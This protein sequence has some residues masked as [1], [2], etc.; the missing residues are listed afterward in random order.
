M[1]T[2]LILYAVI[3]LIIKNYMAVDSASSI[4]SEI[5]N[6]WNSLVSSGFVDKL[7]YIIPLTL[8]LMLI[9]KY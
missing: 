5:S 4:T 3:A 8:I 9:T 6:I 7:T 1:L 2:L